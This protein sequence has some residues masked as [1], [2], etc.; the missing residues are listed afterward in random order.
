MEN[1]ED[2][3]FCKIVRGNLPSRKVYEDDEIVVLHDIKPVAE[4]HLLIIPK[5]HIA[6]M[7]VLEPCHEG[8]LG[9]MM[10]L[11]RKLAEAEGSTDGFRIVVNT[12]KVG[13]QD[14]YHLHLHLLGG[15]GPLP[16]MAANRS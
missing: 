16:G 1:V 15:S 9:R 8:L 7:A 11:A 13:R 10:V 4:V 12:G 6:S 2:C 5:V 3:I 14:V